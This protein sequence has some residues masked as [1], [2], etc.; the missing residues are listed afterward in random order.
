MIDFAF[1][2]TFFGALFAIMNPFLNLPIFLALTAKESVARQRTIALHT[3]F[4]SGV[5]SVI[6][7]L[8][9]YQI[10]A[11]FGVSLEHFR[12][13]GG[14][15]LMSIAFSML[16]GKDITPHTGAEEE[17][18]DIQESDDGGAFYP[19]T[20]PIIVGPGTITTLTVYAYQAHHMPQY[21]A[22]GA[23]LI[24]VLAL[25]GGVLFFASF[26]GRILSIKMRIIVTRVMSMILAAI[27]IAMITEG[28]LELLPGLAGK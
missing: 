16:H 6:V 20:F 21:L 24:A 17:K 12:V 18:G 26:F 23:V 1:A 7:A 15:V 28:L 22:Y 27:A 5:M 13:A 8:T 9:G 10:L 2:S 19:M 11:F 4:Y 14:L 3:T 25:M